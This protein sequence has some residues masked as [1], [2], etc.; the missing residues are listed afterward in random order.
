MKEKGIL[1]Q[2]GTLQK[3]TVTDTKRSDIFG[4]KSFG[5][6]I[7]VGGRSGNS[8]TTRQQS[9]TLSFLKI[10]DKLYEE[11]IIP[12]LVMYEILK[13]GDTIG[14]VFSGNGKKLLAVNNY[15]LDMEAKH[16]YAEDCSLWMLDLGLIMA[17]IGMML[18][19]S[20]VGLG[21]VG[22]LLVGIALTTW[23]F[24]RK[25]ITKQNWLDA[26][27]SIGWNGIEPEAEAEPEAEPEAET[28]TL[29]KSLDI[30]FN[31]KKAYSVNVDK[32]F[33]KQ[34]F[35]S[36]HEDAQFFSNPQFKLFKNASEWYIEHCGSA[37]NQTIVNGIILASPLLITD[38]M[39][40]TVGNLGKSIQKLPLTL[41]I[42]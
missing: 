21:T 40:V 25:E 38:G 35:K 37:I 15:S 5:G 22:I 26:L 1:N 42:L 13:S 28:L 10:G 12:K 7:F 14:L 32:E 16:G 24:K 30:I 41:R 19:A 29:Y 17:I 39:I 18:V 2:I 3:S 23:G 33:G 34:E 20:H 31:D 11:I 9:L 27:R 8:H 4:G 6:G 36:L